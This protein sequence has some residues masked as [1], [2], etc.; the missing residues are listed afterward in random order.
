MCVYQNWV[1]IQSSYKA[2]SVPAKEQDEPAT[3]WDLEI[4]LQLFLI[5]AL[6]PG[7]DKLYPEEKQTKEKN[8][9][10]IFAI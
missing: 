2:L 10:V 5:L 1:I 4:W 9:P 6:Q 7:M 3:G 8:I